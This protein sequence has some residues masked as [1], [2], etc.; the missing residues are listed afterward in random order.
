L[1]SFERVSAHHHLPDDTQPS[2]G[3]GLLRDGMLVLHTVDSC[4]LGYR[5]Y[6]PAAFSAAAY[7]LAL[8]NNRVKK[9][10]ITEK[11]YDQPLSVVAAFLAL[12]GAPTSQQCSSQ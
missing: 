7:L 12:T 4:C 9:L 5:L 10:S 1:A 11:L 2:I 8:H 6:S 3:I